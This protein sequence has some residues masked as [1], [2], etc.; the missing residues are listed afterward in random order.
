MSFFR[1]LWA[2]KAEFPEKSEMALVREGMHCSNIEAIFATVHIALTQGI[3]LTNYVLDLGS[4]N[5]VCGIVESLPFLV[6]FAYLFS[7]MLVRRIGARKPIVVAFSLLHR[8]SWGA[9]IA[10]LFLDLTPFVKQSLMV[11]ALLGANACAVIS[12]NA[13]FSWMA[14]LIP[15]SIRGS[16]YGRRNAY[17]GLTSMI[18]LLVGSSFLTVC[19]D[20]EWGRMGYTICFSTAICSAAFGAWMLWKQYEPPTALLPK[21]SYKDISRILA[22]TKLLK[23]FVTFFSI[24]QFAMGM[25]AAF[26]GVYMVRVL[27]MSPWLM[28]LFMIIASITAQVGSR[29]WGRARD[30]V[31]DRAV[32]LASGTILTFNVLVWLTTRSD[33]MVPVWIIAVTAGIGWSGFNL[34]SFTLPQSLCGQEKLQHAIGLLGFFSGPAFVCGSLLGGVLTTY[35]PE[36]LF[37]VGAFKFRHFYINFILTSVGRVISLLLV[38]S[39]LKE[40]TGSRHGLF[41]SLTSSIRAMFRSD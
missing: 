29:L 33:F 25:T 10:L 15:A 27:E 7:P 5:I 35:L 12:L 8:L 2:P 28:G 6:Q 17:L 19:R 39:M 41:F 13:W 4:S 21:I 38:S 40:A 26:G 23:E 22:E 37:T 16:Y 18:T 31:G 9:L 11:A 3:F 1:N 30:R 24:W 14:D 20:A 36:V 32:L 34:A